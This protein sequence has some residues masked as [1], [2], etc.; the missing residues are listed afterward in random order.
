MARLN[1]DG[2]WIVMMGFIVSIILLILAIVA[3]E[4][5]L[6]GKTTSE[7]VL[8]FSK[9][10]VQDFRAEILTWKDRGVLDDPPEKEKVMQDIYNLSLQRRSTIVDID[11][12]KEPLAD[13]HYIYLH[14][15]NGITNYNE[16]YDEYY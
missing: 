8:E 9:T 5:G 7:S 4:S 15:N 11:Y 10:D 1:D 12:W 16:V 6:V 3:G 14:F 13:I 2:Q